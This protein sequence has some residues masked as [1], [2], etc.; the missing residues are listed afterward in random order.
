MLAAL[1]GA[2]RASSI[3]TYKNTALGSSRSEIWRLAH[4][5]SDS[6]VWDPKGEAPGVLKRDPW[7]W[8]SGDLYSDPDSATYRFQL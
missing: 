2:G 7:A 3:R 5:C 6:E 1:R 8:Q 4:L